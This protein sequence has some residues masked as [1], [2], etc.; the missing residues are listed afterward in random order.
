MP[1]SRSSWLDRRRHLAA[2]LLA[3]CLGLGIQ[4]VGLASDDPPPRGGSTPGFDFGDPPLLAPD[5]GFLHA[6]MAK[7][8]DP[9]PD[10]R[11]FMQV[12]NDGPGF[13]YSRPWSL[14]VLIPSGTV[15]EVA[16]GTTPILPEG[17]AA[18]FDALVEWFWG[19]EHTTHFQ[20]YIEG[21]TSDHDV[22]LNVP[23]DGR[24]GYCG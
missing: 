15:I 24:G 22:T 4:G 6:Q 20:L 14:R 9:N 10:C 18:S 7:A 1:H 21:P 17:A 8:W 12:L 3:S 13:A 11:V 23:H 19:M 2:L 16:S 5:T